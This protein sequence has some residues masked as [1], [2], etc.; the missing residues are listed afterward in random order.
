M[1]KPFYIVEVGLDSKCDYVMI[2]ALDSKNA[3]YDDTSQSP[4]YIRLKSACVMCSY[5]TWET[6]KFEFDD[7]T[8]RYTSKPFDIQNSEISI[9]ETFIKGLDSNNY[10]FTAFITDS[11]YRFIRVLKSLPIILFKKQPSLRHI[12]SHKFMEDYN[13]IF[14]KKVQEMI[15]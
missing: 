6:P 12:I 15:I 2:R 4:C 9:K 3:I 10:L 11:Q 13:N 1:K 8:R 7:N 5:Y 14:I